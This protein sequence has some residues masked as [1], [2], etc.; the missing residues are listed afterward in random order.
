[1]TAGA[2][3]FT[4]RGLSVPAHKLNLFEIGCKLVVALSRTKKDPPPGR[5]FEFA[6]SSARERLL[7]KRLSQLRR[8]ITSAV[9]CKI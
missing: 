8:N 4:L 2:A 7:L 5:V 6:I 3:E 1:M 9:P